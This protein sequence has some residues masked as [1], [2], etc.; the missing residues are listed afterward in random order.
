M[1]APAV[2]GGRVLAVHF[3]ETAAWAR[4]DDHQWQ[5]SAAVFVD[6]GRLRFGPWPTAAPATSVEAA[7]IR[8]VDDEF[9]VLGAGVFPMGEVL[10]GLIRHV[11]GRCPAPGPVDLLVLTCPA[12]W[13]VGRRSRLAAA[14]RVVADEVHVVS[15]PEALFRGLAVRPTG[16]GLV[17]EVGV[18]ES[19]AARPGAADCIRFAEC[20]SV[21]LTETYGAA[22]NFAENLQRRWSG[23]PS[24]IAI[25]GELPA[26][27]ARALVEALGSE[28]AVS[29]VPGSV[30]ASGAFEWGCELVHL[31]PSAQEA[32]SHTVASRRRFRPARLTVAAL[33]V[34]MAGAVGAGALAWMGSED[35]DIDAAPVVVRAEPQRVSAGRATVTVPADWHARDTGRLDRVELVPDDGT[36]ARILVVRTELA[37]DA[38]LTA[39][40]S[41]LRDRIA[42]RPAEVGSLERMDVDARQGLSYV[43]SPD[44]GSRVR[45]RVFVGDQLQISIG[46]QTVPE[47]VAALD[48]RCDQVTRSLTVADR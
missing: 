9:L 37:P 11:V 6:D 14:G 44:P 43:E 28:R 47:R 15:V 12:Y 13:G 20:G 1:A 16:S 24:W 38:D 23:T 4:C 40:E 22:S 27:T 26:G 30:V 18:L 42:E 5:C 41:T 48:E 32:A 21:D 35:S 7:P 25:T 2:T 46:C 3:A 45:W 33:S 29:V 36:P 34:A 17:L 19:V 39:V 8:F 10:G 31:F